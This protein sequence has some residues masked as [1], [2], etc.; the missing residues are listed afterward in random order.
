MSVQKN[1]KAT[2][3]THN[4]EILNSNSNNNNTKWHLYSAFPIEVAQS[5]LHYYYP[6][7]PNC[8]FEHYQLP[9][10]YTARLP[11]R[12]NTPPAQT[13]CKQMPKTEK[14]NSETHQPVFFRQ[15]QGFNILLCSLPWW[16]WHFIFFLWVSLRK[17]KCHLNGNCH[18][19]V[20]VVKTQN[21]WK[22]RA[23]SS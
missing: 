12:R 17:N 3:Q 19:Q 6:S 21:F 11:V 16:V 5:A 15:S 7:G 10:K 9:G 18:D 23:R 13:K 2:I 20:G 14:R 4:A 8:I 1:I 22:A